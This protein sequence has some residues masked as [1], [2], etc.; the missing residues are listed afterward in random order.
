MYI[1]ILFRLF[2]YF[3]TKLYD[4]QHL[5]IV[6]NQQAHAY[7][8]VNCGEFCTIRVRALSLTLNTVHVHIVSKWQKMINQYNFPITMAYTIVYNF[9]A[10]LL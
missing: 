6:E 5:V 2:F 1:N 3:P 9:S 4:L 7:G 8:K 10:F